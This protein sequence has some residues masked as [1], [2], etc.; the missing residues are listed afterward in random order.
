MEDDPKPK[1]ILT[2]MLR[3]MVVADIAR[4]GAASSFMIRA[5]LLLDIL[6]ELDALRA[7]MERRDNN[8]TRN[9]LNWGPCSRHDGRMSEPLP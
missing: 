4:E 8:E 7:E 9:C 6:D 5:G 1:P 2:G 3:D